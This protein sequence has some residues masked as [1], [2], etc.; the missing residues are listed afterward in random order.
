MTHQDLIQLMRLLSARELSSADL[1][2]LLV[3]LDRVDEVIPP[4]APAAVVP[5]TPSDRP[6]RMGPRV[7]LTVMPTTLEFVLPIEALLWEEVR[8][9]RHYC[10]LVALLEVYLTHL[11][12]KTTT[13]AMHKLARTVIASVKPTEQR[14]AMRLI[15]YAA[16]MFLSPYINEFLTVS[17]PSARIE[18]IIFAGLCGTDAQR[19]IAHQALKRALDDELEGI[20]QVDPHLF[21]DA[22]V[23]FPE[24]RKVA[25]KKIGRVVKRWT[26]IRA[27]IAVEARQPETLFARYGYVFTP[28]SGDVRL[29]R[30]YLETADLECY[31]ELPLETA[32]ALWKAACV[33]A[34]I[35]RTT[36]RHGLL[37]KNFSV[38]MHRKE[39]LIWAKEQRHVGEVLQLKLDFSRNVFD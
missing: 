3:L 1:D 17:S 29:L 34:K 39:L 27:S 6:P 36:S 24:L 22:L 11:V 8:E 28:K 9:G 30:E 5:I 16:P 32:K 35:G 23:A 12:L 25:R 33:A 37:D 7:E 31:P 20:T 13:P 14:L 21:R 10:G 15:R 4:R 18:A 19:E 38:A 26:R 2:Q